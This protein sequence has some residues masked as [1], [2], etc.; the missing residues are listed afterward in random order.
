MTCPAGTE[1]N[2]E[3]VD[4]ARRLAEEQAALRRVATLV[5][6]GAT[7]AELGAAVLAEVAQV[8]DTPAAWLVRYES[9]SSMTVV[10]VLNDPA[11][12]AG[13]RWPLDGSSLSATLLATGRP[14]RIDDYSQLTGTIADRTRDSG[15]LSAVG[16]PIT[17]D[18]TV[19]GAICVGTAE[20]GPLPDDT[21]S[22]LRDFTEL[23]ATAI[24]NAE[25]RDRIARLADE[26]AALRRVAMLVAEGAT[27]SEVFAAVA[28]E[29]VRILGV[30]SAGVVQYE[31]EG[32]SVVVASVNDPGFPVG[33]RW[34]LTGP[35]LNAAIFA[36]GRPARI[37]HSDLSGPV[38]ETARASGVGSGV[39]VPIMV[40]G[41][42]WGMVAVGSRDSEE[43][44]PPDTESRLAAFTDLVSTAIS[45]ALAHDDLRRLADEQAALHR[46]A[47]L[48][49]RTAP[50]EQVFAAVAE[51]VAGL[52]A[53]PRIEMVRYGPDGS[54]NVIGASGDH[55][56]P[57]GST[58]MLD[59]PSIMESVFR[60]GRPA[61][62]DDYAELPGTIAN[63]ARAAGFT[64]AIGAPIVVDGATWGSII[65]I[66]TSGEPI[67]EGSETR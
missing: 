18:G 25:S 24:S 8:V 22:R 21:E 62:I 3:S 20:R 63:I 34:P 56:F 67:P 40:D 42:V 30:S 26:Q 16:V 53:L 36:T 43:A 45:K 60:T 55:P 5:A 2:A 58:W 15:F 27:A 31:P 10:A 44:L 65:A 13:S 51:E 32:S 19:W 23:V 54:G 66:S 38:A 64:S 7:S 29:V 11:F 57:V 9:E 39:G 49:A 46:V 61:R 6:Q 52:F 14:A 35:S 12:P 41:S 59:G 4:R 50:P 28:E 37:D 48:V 33:S 1:T 47:A 17:V